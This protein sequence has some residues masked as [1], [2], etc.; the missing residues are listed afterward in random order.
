MAELGTQ[1]EEVRLRILCAWPLCSGKTTWLI[2]GARVELGGHLGTCYRWFC[3]GVGW[4]WQHLV[5]VGVRECDICD[6]YLGDLEGEGRSL[7]CHR[8]ASDL[9]RKPIYL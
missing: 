7:G 9:E 3:S 5:N 2:G 1:T 4:M 8:S 6:L